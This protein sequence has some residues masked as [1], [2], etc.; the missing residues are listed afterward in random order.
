MAKLARNRLVQLCCSIN[1]D[2]NL[3]EHSPDYFDFS[4][5]E[6][7]NILDNNKNIVWVHLKTFDKYGRVLASVYQL[8]GTD[9]AA[10]LIK[11]G[12]AVKYD[13]SKKTHV[14]V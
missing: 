13:G 7:Q 14:W 10:V 12:H 1:K 6:I 9:I 11:E 5:K 3:K 2:Q 8:D 4:K